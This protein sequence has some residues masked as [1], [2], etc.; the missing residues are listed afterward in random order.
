MNDKDRKQIGIL[1]NFFFFL[2]SE[3]DLGN[4]A[5]A[6]F[7][8][9]IAN[10]FALPLEILTCRSRSVTVVRSSYVINLVICTVQCRLY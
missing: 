8:K 7:A 5:D 1:I 3:M 6:V 4:L 10:N 9:L 2:I